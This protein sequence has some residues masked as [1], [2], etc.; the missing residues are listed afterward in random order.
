MSNVYAIILGVYA[1]GCLIRLP[2]LFVK[3]VLG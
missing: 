2:V 1:I 3:K